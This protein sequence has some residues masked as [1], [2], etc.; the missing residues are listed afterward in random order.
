MRL[1]MTFKSRKELLQ[2]LRPMYAQVSWAEKQRVLDGFVAATGYNRKHAIVLLNREP[3][4]STE[5]PARTRKYD[6]EVSSALIEIWKASN[7]ICSKRLVPF[8]PTFIGSLERFGHLNISDTTRQKLLNLSHSSM[9]RLLK[10]ERKKY[11]RRKSTTKPG[12]L[13]KKHIPIRTYSDWN[14]VQPG[15]F[16]ADLVA[17]GGS[18][19]SGQ[20]LHTLTM[21]DIA[22]GWTECKALICKSEISVLRAFHDV[23]ATIP[24][25]LLGLDTDNG[26]E[27]INHGVLDW[28]KTER[29]TFTRSREY[30]KND[31][32]H[33]EEKNGSIVRRLIGHDRFE[34]E[35]SWKI[36]ARLY[37]VARLYVNY[38]QPSLKLSSKEREGGNVR[39]IYE[40]AATPYQRLIGSAHV[41]QETKQKQQAHFDSLDPVMLLTE[42]EKLQAEFWS[43]KIEISEGAGL[44]VLKQFVRASAPAESK[45]KV[46]KPTLKRVRRSK[47]WTP[48]APYPGN[49]KGRKTILDDVWVEVCVELDSDPWMTPRDVLRFINQRYPDKIRASQITTITDK[50]RQWRH[51]HSLPVEFAR[52]KPGKKTN[53]EDVWKLALTVLAEQP[54]ISGNGLVRLLV[55]KHPDIANKGQRTSIFSRLKQWRK[56]NMPTD[57]S[58]QISSISIFEEAFSLV[59]K[60]EPTSKISNEATGL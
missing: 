15:F 10:Q 25:P 57:T 21:T 53:I 49:K 59:S 44:K 52:L 38:F 39:R 51:E 19:A 20:F 47:V 23:R 48:T 14:D 35:E 11:P 43:T 26:S 2:A 42:L 33:V 8:L 54:N 56:E 9:D 55:E 24:F 34:G 37:S 29:I 32:A 13:L 41:P 36:L 12:Y 17:H 4:V 45:V 46:A 18:T 60:L 16:E 31:Q 22:T 5:P 30:K 27:F 7:R 40:Q 28:C 6:D 3:A 50:L 1:K 58:Q